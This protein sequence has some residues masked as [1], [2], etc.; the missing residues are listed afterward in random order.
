M[1][2]ERIY[3]YYKHGGDLKEMLADAVYKHY[4]KYG[5]KGIAAAEREEKKRIISALKK[6]GGK[7]FKIPKVLDKGK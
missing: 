4:K 6:I 5:T 3:K 7:D 1:T 2:N